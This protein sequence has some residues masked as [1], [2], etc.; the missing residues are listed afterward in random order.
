[1]ES[2]LRDNG[3]I[4][5]QDEIVARCPVIFKKGDKEEGSF[6]LIHLGEIAVE[7]HIDITP[8]SGGFSVA[9]P[10]EAVLLFSFW[11]GEPS[12]KHWVRLVGLDSE[13]LYFMN[14]NDPLFPCVRRIEAVNTWVR[15]PFKFVKM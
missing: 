15:M 5:T 2:F 1:L 10:K 3:V 11:D 7:F 12:W 8:I 4:I 13:N 6:P 14:P 9:H